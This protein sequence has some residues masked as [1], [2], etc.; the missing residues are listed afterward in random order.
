MTPVE[1]RETC[2]SAIYASWSETPI[3]WPNKDFDPAVSASDDE[4]IRPT[5]RM[6]DTIEGEKGEYGVGLRTGVL[7]VDIFVG[8]GTGNRA[9]L[10]YAIKIERL[11][12]RKTLDNIITSPTSPTRF[13]SEK[14]AANTITMGITSA[15]TAALTLALGADIP[16]IIAALVLLL[17]AQITFISMGV[18]VSA[19]T[20]NQQVSGEINAVIMFPMMFFSGTFFSIYMMDPLIQN[21]G[22]INPLTYLNEAWRTLLLKGGTLEDILFPLLVLSV[23]ALIS[24]S[25]AI[26]LMWRLTTGM[27][28]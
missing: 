11:F 26:G 18:A 15:I 14:I 23:S 24:T 3:A 8:K 2:V 12:R 17:I 7:F 4:W 13:I 6:G 5:I 22:L 27:Q 1:V 20:P 28:K 21:F 25:I 9:A 19:F 10:N 16:N